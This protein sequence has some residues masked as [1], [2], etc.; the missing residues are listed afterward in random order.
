M[1]EEDGTAEDVG[2][3][4]VKKEDDKTGVHVKAEEEVISVKEEKP[5]IKEEQDIQIK[6]EPTS[7]KPARGKR[8]AK[9]KK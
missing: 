3:E 6:D 5:T 2:A 7:S 4:S 8:S 9:S 1:E